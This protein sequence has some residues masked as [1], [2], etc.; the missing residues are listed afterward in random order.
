M[1]TLEWNLKGTP[2]EKLLSEVVMGTTV[3]ELK[4]LEPQYP[5]IS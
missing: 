2:T 3:S 5:Y 4:S 1:E